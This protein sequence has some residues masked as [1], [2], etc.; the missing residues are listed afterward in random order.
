M[1]TRQRPR[2]AVVG[3]GL[4][5]LTT[6]Y[7]L[8]REGADV[9]LIDK[10]PRLGFHAWSVELE[11]AN[12][13]ALDL[14]EKRPAAGDTPAVDVPMR[15]FQGGYYPLLIALYRHLGLPLSP[16]AFTFSFASLPTGR[17]LDENDTY[18]IHSGASGVSL[19]SLPTQ[20]WRSPGAFARAVL[21]LLGVGLCYIVLLVIAFAS[22]HGLVSAVTF[23]QLV[24]A[25]AAR[26]ERPLPLVR[27]P[28]G[29]VFK[30][31]AADIVLPLFSAVGT[32]TADDVWSTRA[33]VLL[34]Y[35]HAG[36]G[37]SHYSIGGAMSAR[38][39]ARLLAEP[40]RAQGADHVRLGTG[41]DGITYADDGLTL[42]LGDDEI[43][44]D[45]VVVATQ[46][47][48]ARAL[49]ATLEP[50][51]PKP[52][53]R[54]VARMRSALA[55]VHYRDTIVVTHRDRAVLPIPED[56]RDI[57]LVQ[58]ATP[59]V[60]GDATP[61]LASG[62]SSAPSSP[63]PTPR[64][65]TPFFAPEQG[66][67]MATHL[68]A[69][70]GV[71]PVLQ[72]TNPAVPIGGELLGVARLERA[73]PLAD[74]DTLNG[75]HPRRGPGEGRARVFL[76]GSYAYPGIPLLEGCVGSARRVVEDMLGR[77]VRCID[78]DAG[79]GSFAGRAWRWRR[80]PRAGG[81]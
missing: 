53:A 18:F 34:D 17:P 74:D 50:S 43:T 48:A 10:A 78:W 6:A 45:R 27:T 46:A 30:S 66:Y 1:T 65:I 57:N 26:L 33:D 44:V 71:E 79:R 51:L 60:P 62:A 14:A 61:E 68:V 20:A 24:D 11:P 2:V 21:A 4:A 29:R 28:L 56:V 49:L 80:S 41:I 40:V 76:A 5:G 47:S 13:L 69:P 7:L 77:E 63:C 39:V 9:W 67:T 54:R 12:A 23:G 52:E 70:P 72:T 81:Y 19:P 32:M 16:A 75:L 73:L 59:D 38:D 15:S 31:F 42:S 55:D 64:G 37:T 58:P 35:I 22:W 36:V 3:S 25:V 8:T